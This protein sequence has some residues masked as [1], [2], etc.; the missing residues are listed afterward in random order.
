MRAPRSRFLA[1]SAL[2]STALV[3]VA[4]R[5]QPAPLRV[6][7]VA[8]GAYAEALYA[9][10]AGFFSNAGLTVQPLILTSGA[11]IVNAVAGDAADIGITNP[12]PLVNA[13][14]HGIPF[15]Y[16]CCGATNN[17]AVNDLCVAADG[18][19]RTA[20]DLD[21]KTIAAAALRDVNTVAVYAW[22]DRN[23]G[24]AASVKI[25]ELPFAEMAAAVRRGT[26]DA[27]TIPEPAL[28]A[29]RRAGGI[30]AL[31]P[32]IND[33]FGPHWMIGGWFAK[34]QWIANELATAQRFVEAM[35]RTA[36]W[37]N[38]HPDETATILAKYAKQDVA[39]VRTMARLPYGTTLTPE[40]IAPVLELAAR[41]HIIE[42]A[43]N[44]A[45]LIA[46]L[47]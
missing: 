36:T 22:L 24:D 31:L 17:S 10:D 4:A 18:P 16:I 1:A 29:A 9:L 12:I 19:I 47:R 23:G 3:A 35:Y 34:T 46:A 41:Y 20:K 6:A 5:A 21:G 38:G 30:R 15:Q 2:A 42:R 11:A 27:A 28:S 14:L 40:M 45:G 37:A 44:A 43:P 13:V 33:V 7:C 39:V 25:V 8:S 26:V 32:H